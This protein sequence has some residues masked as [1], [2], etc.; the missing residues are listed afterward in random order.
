[1]LFAIF[2]L[3]DLHMLLITSSK[4]SSALVRFVGFSTN[5]TSNLPKTRLGVLFFP[6]QPK[7]PGWVTLD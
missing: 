7:P 3:P 5:P 2:V 1:M 6:S 4:N